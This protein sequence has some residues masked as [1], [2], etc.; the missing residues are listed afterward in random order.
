MQNRKKLSDVYGTTRRIP[1]TYQSRKNVDERFVN[2]LTRDKHIAI[3]GSS[4]QGKSCLRKYHLEDDKDCITIQCT[5][6]TTRAI[7]YEMVL[8]KAGLDYEITESKS[9][10]GNHKVQ[11]RIEGEGKIPF[12]SKASGSGEYEYNRENEASTEKKYLQI[13]LGNP[14][15]IVR[16]LQQTNFDKFIVIEDFHY[17]DEEIQQNLAFDLKVF[18]DVSQINFI[19]IGVW[20]ESN[21]LIL[22]NG[23]L[24]GRVTSINA[25]SWTPS[26]LNKVIRN[27]FSLM[28]ISFPDDVVELATEACQGN[29][30]LLQEICYKICEEN[31]IWTTQVEHKVI[32][33]TK[34]VTRLV[35][36]ISDEHAARY[37]NF[38]SKFGEGLGT[39]ELEMY[40][41]IAWNVVNSEINDLKRGMKPNVIFQKI[42]SEHPKKDTL[43]QN[44][45]SAALER[46]GKVQYKH[47][48]QPI[49][50]DY[51]ND[52]LVVVDANFLVFIEN[53]S[54][55]E[56]TT[57]IGL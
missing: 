13:D 51:T 17:L 19:I 36:Q 43:Q 32:G 8:K 25:D 22:F 16:V 26:D 4:K 53:H 29:V 21:K 14:N 30:G 55:E 9:I 40:K 20:L 50:F 28:N 49:I 1:L 45:V 33:T 54:N 23:D 38:L 27:G 56:L 37:K 7:L 15:D 42:R 39:T 6:D 34:D 46:V 52:E 2:D 3:H 12:V 48:L 31:E 35:A 47:K 24:V 11:V 18:F 10:T 5:R 57:M 44:N 41:W